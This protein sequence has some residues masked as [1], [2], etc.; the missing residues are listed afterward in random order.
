MSLRLT[1]EQYQAAQS[2]PKRPSKRVPVGVKRCAQAARLYSSEADV[3]RAVLATLEL[4][5]RVA[6]VARANSGLFEVQGR[7]IRAGF[8][9]CSDII[10]MLKGG[11]WLAI[12]CKS[13]KGK[14]TAD[15]QA[16]LD[17][18]NGEGGFGFVA[19]SVDDVMAALQVA[20]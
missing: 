5:P 6:W 20:K 4:H 16:F 12:E 3:L 9:G 19:R 15:Q 10:G 18:V 13:D 1:P 11:R 8:K 17:T 2:R 7:F 14:L